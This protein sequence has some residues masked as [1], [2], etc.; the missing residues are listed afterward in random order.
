M[1][2][3]S[4]T[5]NLE[6]FIQHEVKSGRYSSPSEVIREA[7]RLLQERKQLARSRDEEIRRG[8]RLAREQMERGED[9]D[10]Q[11]LLRELRA[12]SIQRHRPW[13]TSP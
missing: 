8:I 9:Q 12:E 6:Q 1:A 2:Y 11:E 13:P 3:V 10:G 5:P 7:V 4:L